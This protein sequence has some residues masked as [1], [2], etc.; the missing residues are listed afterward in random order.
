MGIR[1]LPSAAGPQEGKKNA[2]H[3]GGIFGMCLGKS[4]LAELGSATS[5]FEAVLLSF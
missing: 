2:A 3:T 5:G 4:A 1:A